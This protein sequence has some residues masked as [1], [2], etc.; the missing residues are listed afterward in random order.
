M[1]LRASGAWLLIVPLA[2]IN[3]GLRE[4]VFVPWLGHAPA[5]VASSLLLS[6]LVLVVAGWLI[7]WIGPRSRGRAVAVGAL[8]LVLTVGFEFLAGHYLFGQ[9]WE[10]LFADYNVFQGRV[11]V[12][13][14][15]ATF[16]APVLAFRQRGVAATN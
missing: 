10:R 2:I 16:A 11:W 7:R 6:A 5:H 9:P 12:L 14:L 4:A 3:G 1:F 8:W 15:I 13:V